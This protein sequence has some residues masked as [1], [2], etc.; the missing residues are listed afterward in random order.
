MKKMGMLVALFLIIGAT[1]AWAVCAPQVEDWAKSE[2]YWAKSGGMLLRGIE[3]IV[4]SPVQIACETYK[5]STGEN[6]KYGG[7]IVKGLGLGVAWMLDDIVRGAW[8]IITFAFP[9]YHGEP[10]E[11]KQDCWGGNA[12]GSGTTTTT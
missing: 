2:N 3:R 9:D 6:L 5:G 10:G 11:H 8:D 7:G 12:G 4:E 1:S